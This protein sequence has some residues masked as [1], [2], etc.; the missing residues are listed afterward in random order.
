MM[1]GDGQ[2][3]WRL[4]RLNWLLIAAILAAFGFCLLV[5]NFHVRPLGFLIIYSLAVVY[6]LAGYY[7]V[8]SPGRQNP[9]IVFSL[10]ALAQLAV[11]V[12]TMT[13]IS[14]LA[15]SAN[16]PLMDTKLLALDRALGLDFQ[17]YLNFVND[18]MWLIYILAAG[19]RAIGLPILLIALALPL[20]GYY[21]RTGEFIFAFLLSLMATVCVSTL[22]PAI[23]VYGAMGLDASD[24]TNIVPQGYYD[25]LKDAPL[26]RDGSLRTLDLFALKGVLTFPSFHAVSAIL[27]LWVFWP[28]RWFRPLNLLCSSAMI[29]ATPIGG[30]HFFVDVI[31]GVAVAAASIYAARRISLMNSPA[32]TARVNSADE[33]GLAR[34]L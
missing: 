5:T 13:A 21:Q 12:P 27:Y 33:P 10:S 6:G 3:A 16:L 19:Y 14:Y 1:N 31:A 11:I 25:T 28:M 22:I 8:V 32:R 34:A 26:L 18:R 17:T 2:A 30:G 20:A 4:F 15:A 24:F 23:G 9:R 7:N 29:L